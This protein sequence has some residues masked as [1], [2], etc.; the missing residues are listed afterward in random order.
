MTTHIIIH[1]L[2]HEI[3]WFE[4]QAKQLKIGS[5][6]IN[7]SEITVD[8][9]LNLNLTNW[10]K[11]SIPK[12]FFISKFKHIKSYFDWCNIVFDIN[13]DGSCLGIDDKR[14]KSIRQYNA[15]NFV[16]LD[17]DVVFPVETLSIL[18]ECSKHIKNEY[19]II[20]P[21]VPKL[22][23]NTWD[24]LVNKKY[25]SHHYGFERIVDPYS[26]ISHVEGMYLKPID[27]FKFGG[28]WFNLI[29]S[30]LLKLTD[31]PDSF[32]PYGVDDTYVMEC[33]NIMVSKKYDVKQY[34]VD[35]LVVDED[36]KYR[37][38]NT[39]KYYLYNLDRKDKYR[40][41]AENN[42][43]KEVLKFYENICSSNS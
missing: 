11:S 38:E 25:L 17:C 39:Y 43:T 42:F 37:D 18:I 22:W 23:D 20:S 36:Y 27:T 14:R 19:Y 41:Q 32:G 26:I 24:V 3:D 34:V 1:V 9:T 30:N 4:W 31:I 35:G 40:K 16:Y 2:P 21:Q 28:G 13:E 33:C 6:L 7:G 15:D 29:S 10:M 5:S 8:V 12:S